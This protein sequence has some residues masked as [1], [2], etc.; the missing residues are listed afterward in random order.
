MRNP[1]WLAVTFFTGVL[2]TNQVLLNVVIPLWLVE[3]TDAPR[4]VLAFLFATNTV[5]CIFLPMVASRGVKDMPTALRAIRLS[6]TFFVRLLPD[7]AG[8]PRHRRLGD[9]RAGLARPRHRDRGRALPL[10]GELVLRGRA[11]GPAPARRLPGRRR[12]ERHPGQGL[13]AGGRTPS[14]R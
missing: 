14:S 9:D 12:A 3:Q 1:G 6:P 5:M 13:G 4:V 11:D 7:H 10:G 8:D 2:W